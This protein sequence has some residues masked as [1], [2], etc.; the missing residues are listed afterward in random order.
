MSGFNMHTHT[1]THT[2]IRNL[3]YNDENM[4]ML[5]PP[6]CHAQYSMSRKPFLKRHNVKMSTKAPFSL[7]H[8][9]TQGIF[10]SLS[11]SYLEKRVVVRYIQAMKEANGNST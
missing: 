10:P 7:S 1:H 5:S 11:V 8:I 3:C 2:C 6:S 4:L 9:T